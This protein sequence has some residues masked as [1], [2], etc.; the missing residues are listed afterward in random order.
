MAKE[1]RYSYIS[2]EEIPDSES[3][4]GYNIRESI[5]KL[6]S[7]D[8]PGFDGSSF[9]S[10]N[11][12]NAYRKRY[13]SSLIAQESGEL[14]VIDKEVMNAIHNNEILSENMA[15]E[16]EGHLTIGQKIADRIALFGGSWTFIISFF[17]LLFAW[18][19]INVWI[20]STKAFDP[21]PFI[22]MNLILSCLAAIQAPIIMMS[23][24]RQEQKDRMHSEH[25]YKI[26]LKAELEIR[27]LHEK[28][29]HLIDHHNKR[30]F[31][32]QEIQTDYLEELI[33]EIKK[34]RRP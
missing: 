23:Q 11:E 24:N 2:K 8:F 18:I 31:E 26:N 5:S 29:D 7:K 4:S 1:K 3:V 25:D 10:L 22:L 12:L 15:E 14:E 21:Y 27:L 33:K 16:I 17:V 28:I 19:T 20:L 34:D 13:L 32:I 9:I 30:L 6:I